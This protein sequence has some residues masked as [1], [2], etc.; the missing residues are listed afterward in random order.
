MMREPTATDSRRALVEDVRFPGDAVDDAATDIQA[1]TAELLRGL[2]VLET[3]EDAKKADDA[4]VMWSTYP[5]LQVISAGAMSISKVATVLIAGLGGSSVIVPW[6][7]G[8]WEEADEVLKIAYLAFA[9]VVIAAL[10]IALAIVVRSDVMARSEASAAQY[11]ARASIAVSF[12]SQI[13]QSRPV[14]S[15]LVKR[16]GTANPVPVLSFEPDANTGLVAVTSNDRIPPNEIDSLIPF[17]G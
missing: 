12:V 9:A 8:F 13:P 7:T 6:A 5:S 3:E 14:G 15:Y 2:S 4:K 11:A 16:K 10:L 1:A 17:K